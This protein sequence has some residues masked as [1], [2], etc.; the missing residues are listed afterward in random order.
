MR[1]RKRRKRRR[2]KR[3]R[4]VCHQAIRRPK[5]A[6]RPLKAQLSWK[7]Q[8]QEEWWRACRASVADA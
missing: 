2:R 7:V 8:Q 5:Q 4:Q 1:K 3:K 6:L